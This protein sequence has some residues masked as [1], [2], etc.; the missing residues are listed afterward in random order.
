MQLVFKLDDAWAKRRR[1][2]Q[3]YHMRVTKMEPENTWVFSEKNLPGYRPGNKVK[4]EASQQENRSGGGYRVDKRRRRFRPIIPKQTSLVGPKL[5]HEVECRPVQNKEYKDFM[6]EHNKVVIRSNTKMEIL[7]DQEAQ[8]GMGNVS[9]AANFQTFTTK[10]LPAQRKTGQENKASRIERAALIDLLFKL[11]QEYP[12]WR[13][14]DL[15][16]RTRQP[17]VYLKE[18]LSTIAVLVTSGDTSGTWRLKPENMSDIYDNLDMD[19]IAP[20]IKGETDD[21]MRDD[22]GDDNDEM[23]DVL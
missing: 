4:S 15:K 20:E 6:D 1:V 10:D 2:P 16:M 18:V 21:E 11:F 19:A 23:E 14:R 12:N 13:L 5:D 22:T 8:K 17:E 9:N 7:S 3:L